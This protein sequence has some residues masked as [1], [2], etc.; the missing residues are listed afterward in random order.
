M[1]MPAQE[2]IAPQQRQPTRQS[3][4]ILLSILGFVSLL[5][6]PLAGQTD[7]ENQPMQPTAAAP[8]VVQPSI[9]QIMAGLQKQDIA[10]QV[11][12][13][14]LTWEELQPLVKKSPIAE[15]ESAETAEENYEQRVRALLRRL[16]IRGLFL[17]EVRARG[18]TVTEEEK[19]ANLKELQQ[20]LTETSHGMTPELFLSK[21]STSEST[22]LALTIDDA[23]KIIKFGNQLFALITIQDAE[24]EQQRQRD[25][26]MRNMLKK[27]NEQRR[28]Q[29]RELLEDP[30]IKTDEGFA[31]IARRTSEG[32][33]AR[34]GGELNM[35]FTRDALAKINHL[36]EFTLKA[37]QTSSL[38]ETPT[39]FRIMRVLAE[40]P[41]EKDGEPPRLRVAQLLFMKFPE[42][43]VTAEEARQK[44][45]LEKKKQFLDTAGRALCHRYPVSTPI[46][47]QGLW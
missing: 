39:A 25:Q 43:D 2:I 45:L 28:E 27:Q 47:P 8:A 32:V 23:Q 19:Q 30:D 7:A 14:S 40:V 10:L 24:I 12:N 20:G 22:L 38:L 42:D 18:L 46:F 11:G 6:L 36:D 33:E 3:R 15:S 44:I 35:L 17:Q 4:K 29:L 31:K 9:S 34:Q 5:T 16:A 13:M 41:P 1:T 21:F 37:G 26:A